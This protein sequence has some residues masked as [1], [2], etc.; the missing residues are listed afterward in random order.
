M[1]SP[2][3][4]PSNPRGIRHHDS[5]QT[6]AAILEAAGRIFAEAGLAGA[7]TDAIAAAAGVNKAL[8][9]YYFR[10]K[11]GLYQAVL[12]E[13]LRDF[14]QQA[15]EVLSSRGSARSTLLG[16]VGMHFDFI[17]AR[18]YYPRLFQRMAMAGGKGLER[19]AQEHFVPLAK[20]LVK[21]IERGVRVGELRPLDSA[22][23]AISLVALTVFYFSAAPAV[24]VVSGMDPFKKEN[25]ARRKAE[26][27]KFI[28]YA[29][30]RKPEAAVL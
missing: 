26:V 3:H 6:R 19:L 22:H 25:L 21:L 12:E 30:F 9:Y 27:L 17:S 28:R 2:S 4:K 5:A 10:S 24:R 29:L 16:Y 18:P 23:T 7:R 14:H 13:H 15:L 8:L 20:K 1:R 11:D